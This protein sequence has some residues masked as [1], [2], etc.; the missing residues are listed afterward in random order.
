[1]SENPYSNRL[2][3]QRLA[4]L[5]PFARDIIWLLAAPD[6]VKT[7][8]QSKPTL[9]QLGFT[10]DSL[11]DLLTQ[12]DIKNSSSWAGIQK[13][14]QQRLGLYHEALWH[15]I[16]EQAPAIQPLAQN[17]AIR[18][19]KRTLGELDIV[20]RQQ[21]T[22]DLIHLEVAIKYYLGLPEGPKEN[23]AQCRWIGPAGVDSL[24]IKAGHSEHQQLPLSEHPLARQQL[25]QLLNL[26]P[27]S[28]SFPS[29][30]KQLALP[31]ILFYPWQQD[32][33]APQG[34]TANHHRGWW[35]SSSD[36]PVFCEQLPEGSLGQLLY[37]P[38]W[39]APPTDQ[40]LLPLS[41]LHPRL[42]KHF[43]QRGWP[44]QLAIKTPQASWVRLFIVNP[45]WP[46]VIPL[47]P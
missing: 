6:L 31:G 23:Q 39:L 19:N 7:C 14:A 27:D 36:W 32:F 44:L 17:L 37:K 35:L 3:D 30:H 26:D 20:Y 18:D 10:P 24:A 13:T 11:L 38:H 21:T 9:E 33:P 34:A 22:G 45:F 47:P 46:P 12:P 1:M 43:K 5:N 25:G 2:Y 4:A 29:I 41:Q 15:W 28:S 8:W 40:Q 16:L 42:E